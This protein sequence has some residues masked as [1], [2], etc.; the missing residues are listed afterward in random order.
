MNSLKCL[1]LSCSDLLILSTKSELFIISFICSGNRM[2]IIHSISLSVNVSFLSSFSVKFFLFFLSFFTLNTKFFLFSLSLF[3]LN[4]EFKQSISLN[5]SFLLN[6]LLSTD[7]I[8]LSIVLF[9][10]N[11]KAKHSTSIS[12]IFCKS[13]SLLK[14]AKP[15]LDRYMIR[16]LC[17]LLLCLLVFFIILLIPSLTNSGN[18]SMQKLNLFSNSSLTKSSS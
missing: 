4:T 17:H 3:A 9:G 10:N 2:S 8:I 5:V 11:I 13:K 6:M 7:L 18:L 14:V 16:S 1:Q 15:P 12:E